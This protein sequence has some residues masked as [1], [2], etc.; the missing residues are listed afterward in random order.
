MD[1]GPR[2]QGRRRDERR[3]S[4]GRHLRRGRQ[5]AWGTDRATSTRWPRSGRSLASRSARSATSSIE[6][7]AS[8]GSGLAT[9]EAST[10]SRVI[11]R[12][13]RLRRPG[14]IHHDAMRRRA[15][16]RPRRPRSVPRLLVPM[17]DVWMKAPRGGVAPPRDRRL[18]IG[19][20]LRTPV[21]I[22]KPFPVPERVM[23]GIQ[24]A[25][26]VRATSKVVAQVVPKKSGRYRHERR[27][28][29]GLSLSR[30]SLILGAI[31]GGDRDRRRVILAVLESS[32]VEEGDHRG[33]RA[34]RGPP[35]TA[36]MLLA[37]GCPAHPAYPLC[38]HC[39]CF[40][41]PPW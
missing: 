12:G 20:W 34:A 2:P 33:P 23:L 37:I 41:I 24:H 16:R 15:R 7:H 17:S 39:F 26:C 22:I 8:T 25:C 21:S 19:T 31:V 29:S 36:R 27:E 9:V 40:R 35:R 11:R 13:R 28:G 18:T 30:G 3:G 38:R 6:E 5:D 4:P 32:H 1:I 10:I 14:S